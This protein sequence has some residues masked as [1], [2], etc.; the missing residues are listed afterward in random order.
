MT[1]FDQILDEK[2]MAADLNVSVA[3]LQRDRVTGRYQ[4]PFIK[5]GRMIRYSRQKVRQRLAE[6]EV[7][8]TTAYLKPTV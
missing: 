6:L 3:F 8:S 5:I 1:D 4:I 7:T 2:Q